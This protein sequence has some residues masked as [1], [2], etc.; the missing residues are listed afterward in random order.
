M[1]RKNY[2]RKMINPYRLSYQRCVSAL[3][4]EGF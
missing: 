1:L 4:I 2:M 3:L